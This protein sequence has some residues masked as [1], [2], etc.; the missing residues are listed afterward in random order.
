MGQS[1]YLDLKEME[2]F[3]AAKYVRTLAF[4]KIF[5][6]DVFKIFVMIGIQK[7]VKL[8]LFFTTFMVRSKNS[9]LQTFLGTKFIYFIFL[10]SLFFF[11]DRTRTRRPLLLRTC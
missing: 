3:R 1:D 8:T 4:H 6:S 10:I 2:H 11:H 5:Y 7:E 9:P